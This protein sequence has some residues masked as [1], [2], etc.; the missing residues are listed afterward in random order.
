MRIYVECKPDAAL[1]RTLG[2]PEKSVQHRAVSGKGEVVKHLER[3]QDVTV[4]IEEDPLSGQPGVLKGLLTEE[5]EQYRLKVARKG[6][7]KVV[8]IC[9]NL[10]DW[11]LW[12]AGQAGVDPEEYGLPRNARGLHQVINKRLDSLDKFLR[13]LTEHPRSK[14][15]LQRLQ[16]ILQEV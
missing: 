8:I 13:S 14:E 5:L 9:P 16:A 3:H 7:N 15:V 12:L 6:R 2:F 1:L 4:L 11:L 10:E